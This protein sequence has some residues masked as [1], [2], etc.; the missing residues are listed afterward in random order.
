LEDLVEYSSFT[1][2]LLAI[3]YS[4]LGFALIY[5]IA[6]GISRLRR[7]KHTHTLSDETGQ[8]T[9]GA[10]QFLLDPKAALEPLL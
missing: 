5:F 9:K 7:T 4:A 3:L 8:D 6:F 10:S 1:I 2:K